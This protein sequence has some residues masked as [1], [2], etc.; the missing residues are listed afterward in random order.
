MPH[1]ASSYC[2]AQIQLS[3]PV[4][5]VSLSSESLNSIYTTTLWK[6]EHLIRDSL[7][8]TRAALLRYSAAAA[9]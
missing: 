6:A 2:T 4:S 5:A 8:A 7:G 3:W 1:A 9:A